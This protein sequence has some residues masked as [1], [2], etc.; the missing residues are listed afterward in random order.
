MPY[1]TTVAAKAIMNP[2]Q[3]PRLTESPGMYFPHSPPV[4]SAPNAANPK[5]MS[6][7]MS[8]KITHKPVATLSTSLSRKRMLGS[9]N[10]AL[11]HPIGVLDTTRPVFRI[12][13]GLGQE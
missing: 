1:H 12:V 11:I 9:P 2:Y 4:T 6:T 3:R 8:T 5:C 13:D 10:S 7:K